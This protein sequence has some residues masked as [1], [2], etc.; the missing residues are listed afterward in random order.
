MKSRIDLF[1]TSF[2]L[3]SDE[4]NEYIQTLVA[5]IHKKK[6]LI[7]E[8][9]EVTD[10][11][12]TSILTLLLV[13]HELFSI[14]RELKHTNTYTVH[15]LQDLSKLLQ[16]QDTAQALNTAQRELS[17]HGMDDDTTFAEEVAEY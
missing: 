2:I 14:R 13:T 3:H 15:A 17:I 10:A 7:L 9:V 11:L 4:D 1:D 6:E 16:D 5:Y 12:K 8:D